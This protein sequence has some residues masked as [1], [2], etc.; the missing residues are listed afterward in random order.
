MLSTEGIKMVVKD[1]NVSVFIIL[2]YRYNTSWLT[3]TA[4]SL[5]SWSYTER[6]RVVIQMYVFKSA[7]LS[8]TEFC[9]TTAF[10][11]I[12]SLHYLSSKDGRVVISSLT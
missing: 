2:V 7:L 12:V 4:I 3:Q 1:E 5:N 10:Y 6:E 9:P 11:A 8:I